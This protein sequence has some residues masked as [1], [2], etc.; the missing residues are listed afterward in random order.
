MY[1]LKYRDLASSH[2]ASDFNIEFEASA[3]SCENSA[4]FET[5]FVIK[6]AAK[7]PTIAPDVWLIVLKNTFQSKSVLLF[8]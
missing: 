1:H 5:I 8:I 6:N 2:K 3:L 7:I 4:W